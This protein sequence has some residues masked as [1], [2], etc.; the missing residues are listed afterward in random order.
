[1]K[2]LPLYSW[3][4]SAQK[5][6]LTS[7]EQEEESAS[8][9]PLINEINAKTWNIGRR[10]LYLDYLLEETRE[11]GFTQDDLKRKSRRDP[12]EKRMGAW[13][14][15]SQFQKLMEEQV[16]QV[17]EK[18]TIASLVSIICATLV[19]YFF[20]AVLHDAYVVNF[21]V[22]AIAAAVAAVILVRFAMEKYGILNCY[23][24]WKMT[25]LTDGLAV[26]LCIL[27]DLLPVT[28]DISVVVLFA[29]YWS[30]KKRFDRELK[31][32]QEEIC[33]IRGSKPA[34]K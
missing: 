4:T 8:L 14:K 18:F 27:W 23:G 13:S 19:L 6:Q 15:S 33:R 29:A 21:S 34:A 31:A 3:M 25:A 9:I 1:M 2:E 28:F 32:W 16:R 11:N 20:R 24:S 12:S 5:K 30:E 26:A 10:R 17:K 7:L 22:D